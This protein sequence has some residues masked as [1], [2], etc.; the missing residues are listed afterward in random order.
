MLRFI[1]PKAN[2]RRT[3]F[4]WRKPLAPAVVIDVRRKTE[5]ERDYLLTVNDILSW[6]KRHGRLPRGASF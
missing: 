1:L 2:G 5:I 3:K 6:E 4:H